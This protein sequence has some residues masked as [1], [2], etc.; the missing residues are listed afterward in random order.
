MTQKQLSK[1]LMDVLLEEEQCQCALHGKETNVTHEEVEVVTVAVMEEEGM[2]VAVV[3]TEV[4][5]TMAA[6]MEEAAMV[7]DT[8]EAE[9]VHLEDDILA[10]HPEE[11]M[12]L[13]PHHQEE[14][15]ILA[16][17]HQEEE[18]TLVPH[19]QSEETILA[20][21]ALLEEEM[22]AEVCQEAVVQFP[23]KEPVILSALH[24]KN[25]KRDV[26]I[27]TTVIE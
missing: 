22:I 8:E 20:H 11:E 19:H 1:N 13:V 7:E 2:V 12:I 5:V 25:T 10:R 26:V 21:Q 17:H 3:D 18:M 27:H 15:T 4:E 23:R 24:Q 9:E 16:L 6:V 14:E